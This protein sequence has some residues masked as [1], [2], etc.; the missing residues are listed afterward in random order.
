MG[1]TWIFLFQ[2]IKYIYRTDSKKIESRVWESKPNRT[3]KIMNRSS[4]TNSN[5][6]N[7][8]LFFISWH[9]Y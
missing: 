2:G 5:K 6:L 9:T 7:N 1:K 4:P 3:V 8:V